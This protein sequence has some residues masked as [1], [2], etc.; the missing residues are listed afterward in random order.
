MGKEKMVPDCSII[1]PTRN[2][3]K[4]IENTLNSIELQRSWEYQVE[5]IVID[6]GSIDNTA[7][8]VMNYVTAYKEIKIIVQN[9]AG[10]SSARNNGIRNASGK[11]LFFMDADDRLYRDTLDKMISIAESHKVDLVIAN[12]YNCFC[13]SGVKEK[14]SCL[15]Q[16]DMVLTENYKRNIYERYFIGDKTG[17]ANIWNKLFR[18]SIIEKNDLCF[19]EK[20]THGEDWAFCIGFFQCCNSFYAINDIIYEYRLDGSQTRSKYKRTLA[21]CLVDGHQIIKEINNK[22]LHFKS[23]SNEYQIFMV[24]FYYQIINFLELDCSNA[25]KKTFIKEKDVKKCFR[26]LKRIKMERLY[27][28]GLSRKDKICI[29]LLFFGLYKLAIRKYS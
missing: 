16:Y 22:Y 19:D 4:T 28:L 14:V 13:L 24:S 10:V 25:E 12:Y 6:D 21:Y 29:Y 8:I 2:A 9:N 15:L 17:L 3:E 5:V 23:D 7:E 18:T 27:N 20:R 1:I 11:Y 26:Y